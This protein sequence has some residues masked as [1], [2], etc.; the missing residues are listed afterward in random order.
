MQVKLLEEDQELY[1]LAQSRQRQK[2]ENAMHRRKLKALV[3]WLN[4]LKPWRRKDK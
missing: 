1:V 2:K 3:G 4:H